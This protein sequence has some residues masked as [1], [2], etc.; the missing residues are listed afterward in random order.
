MW[1]LAQANKHERKY[2]GKYYTNTEKEELNSTS[3]GR[4]DFTLRVNAKEQ[5][6][7]EQRHR[8]LSSAE[9]E[10]TEVAVFNIQGGQMKATRFEMQL[11]VSV[12]PKRHYAPRV[13]SGWT[14]E[15]AQGQARIAVVMGSECWC[16]T[17]DQAH[18]GGERGP[19]MTINFL[20]WV[21][22]WLGLQ[23]R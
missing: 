11:E 4:P 10:H 8:G 20:L 14:R 21:S 23:A 12:R 6:E 3:Q 16:Q 15:P 13:F 1:Y 17:P 7:H 19:E 9:P 5:E 2:L 22:V 18:V